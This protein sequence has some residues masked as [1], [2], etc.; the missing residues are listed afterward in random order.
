MYNMTIKCKSIT[1]TVNYAKSARIAVK[2]FED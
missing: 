1:M 2:R